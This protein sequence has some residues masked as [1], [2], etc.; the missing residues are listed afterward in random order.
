MVGSFLLV[1]PMVDQRQTVP[2][3]AM[4]VPTVGMTPTVMATD[5]CWVHR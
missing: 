2:K 3:T 1:V 5:S 4:V